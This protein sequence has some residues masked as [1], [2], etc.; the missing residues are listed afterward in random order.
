MTTE[1]ITKEQLKQ[2]LNIWYQ[3]MLQQKLETATNLKEEVA[4]KI[5]N[6]EEDHDLLLYYALLNYRYK[7]LSDW[8][9]IKENSFD[10]IESFKIPSTGFLAYYYH[11]LKAIHFKFLSNYT[12]ANKHFEKAETLLQYTQNPLEKIEWYYRLGDFY[13]QSYQQRKALDHIKIAKEEFTKHEG[14][15]INVAL[16]NN[17]LGLCFIDLKQFELA[18]E[19]LYAALDAF[20]KEKHEQYVLMVRNNLSLLYT[21]PALAAP[22]IPHLSEITK[23]HILEVTKKN[24]LHFKALLI[25]AQEYYKLGEHTLANES[26][27]KGLTICTELKNKEFQNHFT[28]LRELNNKVPASSLETVILK[29]LPYFEKEELWECVQE[30]TEILAL[31]FYEE[32]NHVKASQYFHIGNEAKKNSFKKSALK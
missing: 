24:P 3:S 28:I 23:R 10:H 26:I 27:E 16:C 9:G 12:A 21:N 30:Y 18:E 7:V 20:Q 15:E 6:V 5:N 14:Y 13:Y 4:N 32:A 8:L 25:E 22:T 17:L 29:A 2:S 1:T 19:T 11:F 31:K